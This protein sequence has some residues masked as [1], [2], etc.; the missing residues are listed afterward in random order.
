MDIYTV[1]LPRSSDGQLG[2]EL[3]EGMDG[4]AVVMRVVSQAAIDAGIRADCVVLEVNGANV[5]RRGPDGIRDVLAHSRSAEVEFTVALARE[6]WGNA[7]GGESVPLPGGGG[8]ESQAE[9]R[10][11]TLLQSRFR[12]HHTRL[13]MHRAQK[14]ADFDT[15]KAATTGSSGSNWGT[16]FGEVIEEDNPCDALVER[17]DEMR[18]REVARKQAVIASLGVNSAVHDGAARR[19]ARAGGGGRSG[20]TSTYWDSRTARWSVGV[21]RPAMT[22]AAAVHEDARAEARRQREEAS[23]S[24]LVAWDRHSRAVSARRTSYWAEAATLEPAAGAGGRSMDGPPPPGG[25]HRRHRIT[26]S[27]AAL[28]RE[29]GGEAALLGAARTRS[30]E[31]HHRA[32]EAPL[33]PAR[34]TVAEHHQR[35]GGGQGVGIARGHTSMRAP[36]PAPLALRAQEQLAPGGGG[37][38]YARAVPAAYWDQDCDSVVS[39]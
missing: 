13:L 36:E 3:A 18:R 17:L 8:G 6:H 19:S 35:A 10:A 34:S 4:N 15:A 39:F 28:A 23:R 25:A 1:W 32:A 24:V 38:A 5:E 9:H 7:A 21:C 33:P 22:A 14:Q 2:V 11:A 12:G 31:R 20:G 29:S 37:Y 16:V 27:L 30:R 26:A